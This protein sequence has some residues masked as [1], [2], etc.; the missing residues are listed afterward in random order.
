[1][2]EAGTLG[3]GNHWIAGLDADTGKLMWR[4]WSIRPGRAWPRDVEKR[5]LDDGRGGFGLTRCGTRRR[6]PLIAG[7]G[8]LLSQ[9]RSEFRPGDNLYCAS[10]VA[11]RCRYGELKWYFTST[12]Q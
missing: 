1:M 5:R 2:S 8:R 3:Y 7:N 4:F 9:L 12:T 10:S 6:T 11:S